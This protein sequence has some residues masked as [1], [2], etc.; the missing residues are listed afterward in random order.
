MED[1]MIIFNKSN[2]LKSLLFLAILGTGYSQIKPKIDQANISM[3]VSSLEHVF[4]SINARN[5]E[6]T[7]DHDLRGLS[8]Y[9]KEENPPS[10]RGLTN[11][12]LDD[13]KQ[14]IALAKNGDLEVAQ[15]L[16]AKA[17][18]EVTMFERDVKSFVRSIVAPAGVL[19]PAAVLVHT[20]KFVDVLERSLAW[21]SSDIE[22]YRKFEKAAEQWR[23]STQA[24]IVG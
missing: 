10:A 12:I 16:V 14:V 6:S 18:N 13:L 19:K 3:L 4:N 22:R 5:W 21:A 2:C 23:E 1:I 20:E 7:V 17:Q 15:A 9:T 8:S 24:P 11:D